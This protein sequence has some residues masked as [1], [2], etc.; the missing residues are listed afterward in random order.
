MLFADAFPLG[1]AP[2]TLPLGCVP[3]FNCNW[4]VGNCSNWPMDPMDGQFQWFKT[5]KRYSGLILPRSKI[6]LVDLWFVWPFW[7]DSSWNCQ[8]FL[9][10]EE[11][12]LNLSKCCGSCNILRIYPDYIPKKYWMVIFWIFSLKEIME[13]GIVKFLESLKK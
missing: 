5:T 1:F 13:A 9:G 8:V 6:F 12:F 11:S 10:V 2:F 7:V 3:P 4:Q